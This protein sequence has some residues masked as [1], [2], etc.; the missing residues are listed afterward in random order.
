MR[1]RDRDRYEIL[2]EL[3]VGGMATVYLARLSGPLGFHRLVA[4][5][6]MHP[7]LAADTEFTSMFID[8]ARLTARLHHPNIVSTLDI[9]ADDGQLLLV[10]EFVDGQSLAAIASALARDGERMPVPVACALVYDAL[11]GLHEAH[12]ATDDDG[13]PLAVVH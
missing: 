1:P 4:V 9:V 12:E 8:E 2:G 13:T 11:L 7:Q 6:H 3:A 5:K 10:M